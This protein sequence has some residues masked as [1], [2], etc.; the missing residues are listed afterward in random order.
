VP[1]TGTP[2]SLPAAPGA[3]NQSIKD[4]RSR[5]LV[6]GAQ[7]A[8]FD[9]RKAQEFQKISN[10]IYLVIIS[11]LGN[12]TFLSFLHLSSYNTRGAA[13][14]RRGFRNC[15]VDGDLIDLWEICVVWLGGV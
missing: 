13:V 11:L 3:I 4:F 12:I 6:M 1:A 7:I 2:F 5:I 8:R 10:F 9:C 15:V 14:S